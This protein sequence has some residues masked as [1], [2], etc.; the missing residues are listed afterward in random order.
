MGSVPVLLQR[1]TATQAP[2][3]LVRSPRLEA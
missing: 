2:D 3:I 1:V